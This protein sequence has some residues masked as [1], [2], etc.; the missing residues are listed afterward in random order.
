MRKNIMNIG[1][2][3][4]AGDTPVA[5]QETRRWRDMWLCGLHNAPRL[6]PCSSPSALLLQLGRVTSGYIGGRNSNLICE[7]KKRFW[8]NEQ[9]RKR[10]I[11]NA[12]WGG[13]HCRCI[14]VLVTDWWL[15]SSPQTRRPRS[16]VPGPWPL[17][18]DTV[19]TPRR[20]Q[21]R[22]FWS[23][24]PHWSPVCTHCSSRAIVYTWGPDTLECLDSRVLK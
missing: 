2:W 12:C 19:V 23:L 21:I 7:A 9:K 8:T 20:T 1:V 17:T 16:R 10:K 5:G 15:L 11:E 13:G 18:M 3:K 4:M 22:I 14:D 6:L 24:E